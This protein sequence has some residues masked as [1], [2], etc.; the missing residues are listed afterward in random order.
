LPPD[1][2]PKA[3]VESLRECETQTPADAWIVG[4]DYNPNVF[5]H[6]P[7]SRAFL[8]E[9]FPDRPIFLYEFSIHH[10]LVNTRALELAGIDADTPNPSKGEIRRDPATGTAT[11]ELIETATALVTRVIPP[12]PAAAYSKALR[13][14]IDRCHEYGITSIQEASATRRLLGLYRDFDRRGELDLWVT[15]HIVWGSEKWGDA[16]PG[17]LDQLID[18]R[19]AFASPHLDVDATKVWLDGAPL[20]PHYSEAR[21]DAHTGLPDPKNLLVD[22]DTLTELDTR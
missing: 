22:V 8:D 15:A 20:P 1:A 14:G 3:I 21:I 10:A 6:V 5:G 12:Y 17:E 4:G 16:T 11:G 13:F 9:A 18:E 2:A 19:G 7:V